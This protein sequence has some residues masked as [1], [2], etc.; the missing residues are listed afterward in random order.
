M[1]LIFSQDL[2]SSDVQVFNQLIVDYGLSDTE[3]EGLSDSVSDC[4]VLMG[5]N[6]FVRDSSESFVVGLSP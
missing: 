3:F 2:N 5:K 6:L 4:L 1:I